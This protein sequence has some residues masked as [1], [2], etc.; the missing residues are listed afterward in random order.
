MKN[1]DIFNLFK[2]AAIAGNVLFVLWILANGI[3]E[4]FSG[5]PIE[6]VSYIGLI[7]L[8]MLNTVLLYRKGMN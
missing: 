7:L 4:S 1:N 8:L 2:Y 3:Y 6:V 5:T